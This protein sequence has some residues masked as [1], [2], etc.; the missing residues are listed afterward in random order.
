MVNLMRIVEE[1]L[2]NE[3]V[4]ISNDTVILDDS[5]LKIVMILIYSCKLLVK[6]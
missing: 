1:E 6:W 2:D 4:N 5:N 3:E